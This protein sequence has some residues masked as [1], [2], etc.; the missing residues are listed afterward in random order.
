MADSPQTHR[1]LVADDAR[2]MRM[3][4]RTWLERLGLDVE[5]ARNGIEALSLAKT[6]RFDLVMLDINMPGLTGL[7]V[8]D[9]IR[10]DPEL[11]G[12]PVVLLT[13]L[14]NAADVERGRRLGAS[15]Y[16]TKPISFG[17]LRRMLDTQLPL[18]N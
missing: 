5:E 6:G 2:V 12:L 18:P 1:V 13:T 16:L 17:T 9:R 8:L 3:L 7:S 15:D 4:I 10:T 14:G 11:E